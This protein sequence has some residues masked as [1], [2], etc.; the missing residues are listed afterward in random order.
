MKTPELDKMKAAKETSQKIGEFIEWLGENGYHICIECSGGGM[1]DG[2]SSE[3]WP[4]NESIEKL[5]AKY[6]NIDLN[7]VEQEKRA[8]LEEFR[9]Q[10]KSR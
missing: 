1:P 7:K 4:C 9:K 2:D 8:I 3:Y 6:Y 10:S 5:L